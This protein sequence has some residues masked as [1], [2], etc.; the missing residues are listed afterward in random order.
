MHAGVLVVIAVSS[1]CRGFG[2]GAGALGGLVVLLLVRLDLLCVAL[3][4]VVEFLVLRLD[5]GFAAV[6]VAAA[7][8]TGGTLVCM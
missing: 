6:C 8:G 1:G 5:L 3:A 4:L 7:A 2:V